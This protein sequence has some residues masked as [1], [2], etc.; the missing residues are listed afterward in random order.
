MRN[1]RK[2]WIDVS[3]VSQ[4]YL[5]ATTEPSPDFAHQVSVRMNHQFNI[6]IENIC[7]GVL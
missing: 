2:G 4:G 3:E 5:P 1:S 7:P 6:L